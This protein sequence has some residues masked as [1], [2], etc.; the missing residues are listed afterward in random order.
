MFKT[1]ARPRCKV[2]SAKSLPMTSVFCSFILY[3]LKPFRLRRV[4]FSFREFHSR[5][6]LF[7][8]FG[9]VDVVRQFEKSPE[10]FNMNS[11]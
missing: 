7:K 9:L 6:L 1:F 10:Y 3:V 2:A 4:F 5:L 8:P 11:P